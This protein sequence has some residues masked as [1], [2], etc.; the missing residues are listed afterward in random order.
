MDRERPTDSQQHSP[1]L[2]WGVPGLT[3]LQGLLAL[4]P[5]NFAQATANLLCQPADLGF[6][7]P[8]EAV[9]L[10]AAVPT[11]RGLVGDV[12]QTFSCVV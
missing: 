4:A 1:C 12:R 9:W 5:T 7:H 3:G 10:D 8:R 2:G 6:Q 11:S